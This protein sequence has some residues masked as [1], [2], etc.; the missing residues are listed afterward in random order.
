MS[1]SGKIDHDAFKAEMLEVLRSLEQAS[2][3]GF[4][5]QPEFAFNVE[6]LSLVR[7]REALQAT[8]CLELAEVSDLTSERNQLH[9]M[10]KALQ[11]LS[12]SVSDLLEVYTRRLERYWGRLEEGF[13]SLPD[14]LIAHIF[15]FAACSDPSSEEER[16]LH[17]IRFSHV[18]R[19]L[20]GVSL[21]WKTL[22]STIHMQA[23]MTNEKV[24]WLLSR[25]GDT[26]DLDIKIKFNVNDTVALRKLVDSCAH[27]ASRWLSLTFVGVWDNDAGATTNFDG[28]RNVMTEQLLEFPQLRELHFHD[29]FSTTANLANICSWVAPKLDVLQCTQY[30]PPP[31]FPNTTFTTFQ[32]HLLLFPSDSQRRVRNLAAF[33]SS[34]PNILEFLLRLEVPGNIGERPNVPVAASSSIKHFALSLL[35]VD[36]EKIRNLYGPILRSLR[37]PNLQTFRLDIT[38]PDLG[39]FS[40]T[41]EIS[42]VLRFLLPDH[43]YHSLLETIIIQIQFPQAIEPLLSPEVRKAT[44]NIPLDEILQVCCLWITTCG[45][46]SF[47]RLGANPSAL[48]VLQFSSCPDL[49]TNGLQL[50]VQSLIHAGVW[51]TLEHVVIRD[52]RLLDY[53]GALEA[54]GPEGLWY[55]INNV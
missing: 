1:T 35:Q 4:L 26:I 3:R 14:E 41:E 12:T 31:S 55:K 13:A 48:R 50:A 46:V 33:L 43:R 28:S 37:A 7:N 51:A 40:S 54:I 18:S 45:Q 20:R 36:A 22:W 11:G 52:C 23:D 21:D 42:P 49:D 30:I 27:T 53:G 9:F 8:G 39:A 34:K 2:R 10:S 25:C 16:P 44:L 5:T 19:R 6:D 17:A 38:P 24:N 32:M 15:Q 29:L 47:S